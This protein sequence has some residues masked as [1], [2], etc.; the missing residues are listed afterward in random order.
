VAQST[1]VQQHICAQFKQCGY[2]C[3]R[4]TR[5]VPLA[6]AHFTGLL[7][8]C[9]GRV[10]AVEMALYTIAETVS[11]FW[12]GFMFDGLRLSTQGSSGVMAVI[13]TAVTVR[14]C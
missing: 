1:N 6:A 11:G 10:F 3:P 4:H 7:S 8:A 5:G 9:A 2:P 12:G 13:A 14:V